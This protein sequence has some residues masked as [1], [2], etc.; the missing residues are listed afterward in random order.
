MTSSIIIKIKNKYQEIQ[1]YQ[2]KTGTAK[3]L[4]IQA[5]PDASYQLIDEA[6][7]FGPEKIL[8]KRVGDDLL[9]SFD[10]EDIAAGKFEQADLVIEN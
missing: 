9:I 1:N 7:G 10:P 4:H 5:T 3:T 2:L 8:V 6:T